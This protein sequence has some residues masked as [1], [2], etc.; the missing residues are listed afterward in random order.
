MAVAETLGK[1]IKELRERK[2][3]TQ[4]ALALKSGLSVESIKSWE[5]DRQRPSLTSIRKLAYCLNCKV[6]DLTQYR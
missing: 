6:E 4:N 3:L 2:A 1:K 5:Q